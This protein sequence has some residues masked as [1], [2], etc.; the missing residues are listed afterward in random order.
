M[1]GVKRKHITT[2]VTGIETFHKQMDKAEAGDNIGAL[3][4]GVTKDMIRR[5]MCLAQPKSMDVR[6]RIEGEIYV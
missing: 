5:G 6:R 2:T 4:R 3:L 1:I